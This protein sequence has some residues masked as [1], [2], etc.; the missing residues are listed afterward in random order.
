MFWKIIQ[1]N[2]RH[3]GEGIIRWRGNVEPAFHRRV[4]DERCR[5]ANSR[6]VHSVIHITVGDY[7]IDGA[8]PSISVKSYF[9]KRV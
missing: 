2:S 3:F 8:Y 4:I 6:A 5:L 1:F 9:P 7:T